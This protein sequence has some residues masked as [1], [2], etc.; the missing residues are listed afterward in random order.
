ME[1]TIVNLNDEI[2]RL[3][4]ELE[5]RKT[6][7]NILQ[8]ELKNQNNTICELKEELVKKNILLNEVN[9]YSFSVNLVHILNLL[10]LVI[11]SDKCNSNKCILIV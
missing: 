4:E 6:C 9:K 7:I 10:D 5:S 3:H 8:D 1:D 11:S 2:Q